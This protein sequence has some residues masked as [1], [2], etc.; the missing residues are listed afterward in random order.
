[1]DP[2]AD[3]VKEL[4]D[5]LEAGVKEVFESEQY[6]AYLKAM[7]KFHSY[8]FGNVMLILLQ[9]PNASLVAGFHK[10]KKDFGRTVKKGRAWHTDSGSMST[11]TLC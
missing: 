7:S 8:S 6:K 10:W 4:L 9:C 11:Q 3:K 2:V 5:K 1:M